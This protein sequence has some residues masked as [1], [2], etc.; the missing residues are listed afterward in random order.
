M[1]LEIDT[2]DVEGQPALFA[3]AYGG[4]KVGQLGLRHGVRDDIHESARGRVPRRRRDGLFVV[5][6]L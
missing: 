4:V 1:V 3:A 2:G 5:Q 6:P